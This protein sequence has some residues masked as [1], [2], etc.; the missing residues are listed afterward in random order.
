MAS[1]KYRY[2]L[3]GLRGIAIAFVVIFHVFVGRVSGGVDVFLLLSGYF[4]LGGQLRYA[5]K[6]NASLNP[7]WPIWRTLR[8]LVPS[9]LFVLVAT[10]ILVDSFAPALRQR[11]L[12]QEFI[13]SL[14]YWQNWNLIETGQ[15]YG[16]ASQSISPLQHL[17]SMSVQGQF[18][19][20]T[21]LLATLLAVYIKVYNRKKVLRDLRKLAGIPLAI[22]TVASFSYAVYMEQHDQ[23]VNY[24]STFTRIWELTLGAL[25]SLYVDKIKVRGRIAAPVCTYVGLTMVLTTG[26]IFD[27]ASQF[28]GP[29]V[30]YPLFGA[31]LIICSGGAAWM[32][33]KPM[34]WL[35]S[36]AYALYLWHWPLLIIGLAHYELDQATW[37][38]GLTVIALSVVLA[39]L[40]HKYIEVPFQQHARRPVRGE[41]RVRKAWQQMKSPQGAVQITAVVVVALLIAV[42]PGFRTAWESEINAVSNR[43]LDPDLYPGAMALVGVPVPDVEPEPDPYMLAETFPPIW[44]SGCMNLMGE[45][46]SKLVY[47]EKEPGECDF[48]DTK[49]DRVMALIGGSHSEQW[50]VPLDTIAKKHGYRIVPLLRQGCPYYVDERDNEFDEECTEFNAHVTKYLDQLDPDVVITTATRPLFEQEIFSDV[51]PESYETGFEHL[52]KQGFPLIG[53]RDNPWFIA[54]GGGNDFIGQCYYETGDYYGCGGL[55]STYYSSVDPALDYF[56]EL[57]KEYKVPTLEVDTSDWFCVDEF[58]PAVIGNIF[59][60]RDGNHMS[61]P[62]SET[63]TPLL[64][65]QIGPFLEEL[66]R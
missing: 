61:G 34:R 29:A 48:G 5:L 13:A 19:L 57:S 28:P 15:E 41:H 9:L 8:R 58:C 3:D 43:E 23:L 39:H 56:K 17:W 4:F 16:A 51:L 33:A 1:S 49:S 60:Y 63:I 36:I 25:L 18:Y 62:Y 35:G 37:Q 27:G 64:E 53:L 26:L 47:E 30:L 42:A 55:R 50:I 52:A 2:D 32:A 54:E 59:V 14:T 65:Q 66:R 24:Y 7:W 22:I 20:V 40:T 45:D 11:S 12:G 31:V 6:P 10:M 46:P 44:D 38:F 21:I